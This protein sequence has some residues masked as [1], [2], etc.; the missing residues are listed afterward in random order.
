MPLLHWRRDSSAHILLY[1]SKRTS[2]LSYECEVQQ[3]SF[4]VSV[5]SPCGHVQQIVAPHRA[6]LRRSLG[7]QQLPCCQSKPLLCQPARDR[8]L[9]LAHTCQRLALMTS[10]NSQQQR[11]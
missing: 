6:L 5:S 10:W 3:R 9:T 4:I 8:Q 2:T 11:T 7:S 1:A